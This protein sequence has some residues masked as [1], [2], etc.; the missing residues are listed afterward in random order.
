VTAV[1]TGAEADELWRWFAVAAI[2]VLGGL[3]FGLYGL[4][5]GM[6]LGPDVAPA[7]ASIS[8]TLFGFFGNVFMPLDGAMLDIARFTPMY[9]YVA[10]VRWPITDGGLASGATDP[11]WAVL[12]N[13]VVWFALFAGLARIGLRRSRRRA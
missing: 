4:G 9:G 13:V 10:L 1:F 11:L 6:S 3:M 8:I 7:L 2:I 12:L 5:V